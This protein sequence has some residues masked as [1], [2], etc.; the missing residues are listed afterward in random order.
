MPLFVSYARGDAAVVAELYRDLEQ[1][2]SP[3]WMD[4]RLSGGQSWWDTILEQIRSCDL[5]VVAVSPDSIRSEACAA[6]LDYA[7]ALHRPLLP[8]LVRNVAMELAEP[9]IANTQYVDYRSASK[10]AA[11]SLFGAVAKR[12]TAPALPDP[13]PTPPPPPLSYMNDYREKVDAPTLSYTEQAHLMVDLR[14]FLGRGEEVRTVAF[15]LIRALRQRRD[16]AENVARDIDT[17]LGAGP[18]GQQPFRLP[19]P[20]VQ[21]TPLVQ[22]ARPGQ[23]YQGPPNQGP[24]NQGLPNQTS[25]YQPP[26]SQAQPYQAQPYQDQPSSYAPIPTYGATYGGGTTPASGP[27]SGG[28]SHPQA[29]TILV[30][31]IVGLVLCPIAGIVA[32]SMS[33]KALREVDA[34]PG[35]YRD[36]GNIVA[37]K[38]LGIVGVIVWSIGVFIWLIAVAASSGY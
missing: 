17:L 37:G 23:S 32:W 35:L 4:T 11:I 1:V 28:Q 21:P 13:L 3:V 6:E 9:A 15:Q 14:D 24:P 36:R 10:E 29:L 31:G 12:P 25:P 27:T 30:L 20:A 38:W 2:H 33:G 26:P 8:V 18:P 22:P 19:T 7:L 34:S 5:F 16:I